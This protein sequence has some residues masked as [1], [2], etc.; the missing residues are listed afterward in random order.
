MTGVLFLH[1]VTSLKASK[2]YIPE[3]K[4]SKESF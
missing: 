2:V 3:I 1:K 4:L